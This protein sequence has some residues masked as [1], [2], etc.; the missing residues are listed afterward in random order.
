MRKFLDP[1]Q[2]ASREQEVFLIERYIKSK[3]IPGTPLQ[4][5]EAG[6]GQ[7]WPID[8]GHTKYV[9]TGIDCDAAALEIRKYIQKDIHEAIEGDLCVVRL[10]ESRFDVIYNSFVLEH[11]KDAGTV[12][13]NFSR[14]LKPHGLLIIK[15]P[16][17]DSVRGFLTRIT[18]HWFHIFYYKYLLGNP[19]AGKPGFAPYV[20]FYHPLV[21]RN[22]IYRFCSE[23]Q[24]SI[25]EECGD[26]GYRSYGHGLVYQFTKLLVL[27]IA[28]LSFGKLTSRYTN[29]LYIL[30]K[31]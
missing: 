9:L 30:E 26:G 25:R 17:P 23:K 16:D 29:L 18:P 20:T 2:L 4:I 22:G 10:G 7:K 21:S 15:I 14:W 24:F 19:N 3:A 5:L 27:T 1:Q 28:T 13:E 31:Q 12:L 6:C 11:V 8:L